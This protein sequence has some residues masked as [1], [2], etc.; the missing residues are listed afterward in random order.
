MTALVAGYIQRAVGESDQFADHATAALRD[1]D[2]RSL[3]A[4]DVTDRLVLTNA[5]DLTAA[6]PLIAS[7]V[8][9]VVGGPAFTQVL[10][11]GGARYPSRG[12]RP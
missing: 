6:R 2:V 11:L 3:I 8:S 1:A 9:S 4:A 5:G 10:P 12:V 7:V